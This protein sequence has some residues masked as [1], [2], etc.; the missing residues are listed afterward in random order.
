MGHDS[1]NTETREDMGH[2]SLN[3]ETVNTVMSTMMIGDC[4][5][6]HDDDDDDDDDH[7]CAAL[8]QIYLC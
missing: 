2:E 5:D 6:V 7:D 3:N 4:C 1:L 8:S